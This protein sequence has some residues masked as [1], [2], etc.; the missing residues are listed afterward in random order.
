MIAGKL[1]V[2]SILEGSVRKSGT[3]VRISA[4]LV[5]ASDGFQ[6][7]SE[8]YDRELNDIF[9]VQDDI[10]HSVADALKV[11]LLGQESP[12]SKT[13]N[14]EAYNAYLQG[15]YFFD[16]RSKEDLEKAGRLL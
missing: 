11:K 7:W 16:R 8:T 6:L 1:Q 9:A 4:Q 10:A 14:T 12:S 13:G 15:R 2:T 5:N 3:Q